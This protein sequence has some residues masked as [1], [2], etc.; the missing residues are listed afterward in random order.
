[1][2]YSE[3]L[4]IIKEK[5]RKAL[6]FGLGFF[7]LLPTLIV[8]VYYCLIATPQYIST[9]KFNVVVESGGGANILASSLGMAFGGNTQ[10]NINE[11][12]IVKEFLKSQ[13][14]IHI[15][16]KKIN[17]LTIFNNKNADFWA[18]PPQKPN[19]EDYLGYYIKMVNVSLNETDG[20]V[21]L[22]VAA[23]TP[24]NAEIIAE[25]IMQEAEQFVNKRSER[26]QKDSIKFAEKFLFDAE[27]KVLAANISL[28]EFRNKNQS[29]D[30][31]VT[32]KGVLQITSQLEGELAKTKTEIAT[33]KNYLKSDNPRIQNLEAKKHSLE[34]QIKSQSGRLAAHKGST[35]ADMTQEYEAHKLM[36]EFAVKRYSTAIAGLEEAR[37]KAAQQM[38]YLLRVTGPTKPEKSTKPEPLKEILGTFFVTLVMFTIGGLIL[39]A[40][41]D[42]IRS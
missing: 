17:L 35:L 1:M 39:S 40:L 31:T 24:K 14:I 42:H 37:A 5:R 9:T 38:K 12:F 2:S 41:K 34:N 15:L 4:K 6:T 11:A 33:L 7:V 3:E 10:T 27:Q 25:S 16:D 19:I 23:F 32:A 18:A 29:F 13:D 22:N 8:T 28:S 21:T 36:T 30:P 26:M 20:F